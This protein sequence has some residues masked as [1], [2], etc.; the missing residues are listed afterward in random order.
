MNISILYVD[1]RS[2]A[3][4]KYSIRANTIRCNIT[5]FNARLTAFDAEHYCILSAEI[6]VV[7]ICGVTL[8][9]KYAAIDSDSGF[10]F[11]DESILVACS[12]VEPLMF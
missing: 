7:I 12:I 2:F 1:N 6:T 5:I 11:S 4:G 10:I 3:S 9:I 8:F